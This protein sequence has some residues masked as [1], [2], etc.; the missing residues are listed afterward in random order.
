MR[1]CPLRDAEIAGVEVSSLLPFTAALQRKLL[2][3]LTSLAV[4]T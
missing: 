1:Q 4:H 3:A 2:P